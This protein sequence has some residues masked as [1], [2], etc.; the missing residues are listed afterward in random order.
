MDLAFEFKNYTART[1]KVLLEEDP[2]AQLTE[3]PANANLH[4]GLNAMGAFDLGANAHMSRIRK[5]QRPHQEFILIPGEEKQKTMKSK[6]IL[7]SAAFVDGGVYT[8]F[9]K[10]VTMNAGSILQFSPKHERPDHICAQVEAA[11]MEQ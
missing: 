11:S 1:I 2:E 9:K 3:A 5:G 8:I 6:C 7:V 10:Q 4:A